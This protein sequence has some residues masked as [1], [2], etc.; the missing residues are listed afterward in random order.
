[1]QR[2]PDEKPVIARNGGS[3]GPLATVAVLS[4]TSCF[5]SS[6]EQAASDSAI[7]SGVARRRR[8]DGTGVAMAGLSLLMSGIGSV[9]AVVH[10]VDRIRR[11]DEDLARSCADAAA[12]VDV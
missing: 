7:T 1:M 12:G 8:K 6:A 4:T 9:A 11:E 2:R 3:S 5:T 10:H